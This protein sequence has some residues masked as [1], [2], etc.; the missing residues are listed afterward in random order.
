MDL[1][2][3]LEQY[4]R[5]QG[6]NSVNVDVWRNVAKIDLA[7]FGISDLKELTNMTKINLPKGVILLPEMRQYDPSNKGMSIDT[8]ETGV[9]VEVKKLCD[10]Y[11]VP[12]IMLR[13]VPTAEELIEGMRRLPQKINKDKQD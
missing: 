1:A 8:Y 3:G 5:E 9:D 2:D 10:G 11:D 6:I 13:K 4:M 7:F 12:L